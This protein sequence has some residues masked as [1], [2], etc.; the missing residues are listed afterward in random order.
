MPSSSLIKQPIPQK[1]RQSNP[2]EESQWVT[3][4]LN[5]HAVGSL[6]RQGNN[7]IAAEVHQASPSSPDL[8]FDLELTGVGNLLPNVAL[9][10][11]LNNAVILSPAN[12]LLTASASDAY[13]SVTNVQFRADGVALGNVTTPPYQFLWNSPTAGWHS[14]TAVA[15]DNFGGSRVS[16]AVNVLIAASASLSVARNG[17]FVQLSWPD[18]AP[19]YTLETATNL[20]SPIFWSAT[21]NGVSQAGGQFRVLVNP[22]EAERYFRLRAP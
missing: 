18:S 9:T 5:L 17:T 13:G 22:D 1:P 11:P 19:G 21:T 14:L 7:V 3:I 8:S 4:N 2:P 10:S 6:L 20:A 15:I 16:T 12:V